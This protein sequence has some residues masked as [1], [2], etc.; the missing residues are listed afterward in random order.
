MEAAGPPVGDNRA[1]GQLAKAEGDHC[2][3]VGIA[4]QS[5]VVT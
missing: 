2:D 4:T 1:G 3:R 5:Q